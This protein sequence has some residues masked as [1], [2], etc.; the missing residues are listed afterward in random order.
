MT[1]VRTQQHHTASQPSKAARLSSAA[2]AAIA[3]SLGGGCRGERLDRAA[4]VHPLDDEVCDAI[5]AFEVALRARC[6][7]VRWLFVEP[8]RPAN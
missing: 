1:T 8:D 4:L 3:K 6:P 5:N 2:R 7:E